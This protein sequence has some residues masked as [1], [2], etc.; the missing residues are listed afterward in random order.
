[1]QTVADSGFDLVG[2]APKS[3]L[4]DV[5]VRCRVCGEVSVRAMAWLKT[6]TCPCVE[7]A[8]YVDEMRHAGYEPEGPFPGEVRLPWPSVCKTCH[9][10]RRVSLAT[11]RAGVHCKHGDSWKKS[12]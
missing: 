10:L 9:Q 6:H 11:V 5:E 3:L 2:E 4:N 7:H 8:G 12:R 1:M